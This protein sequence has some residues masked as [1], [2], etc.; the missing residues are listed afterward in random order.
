MFGKCF[1]K[2]SFV[3][4]CFVVKRVLDVTEVEK[5]FMW[6]PHLKVMFVGVCKENCLVNMWWLAAKR[7]FSK[8]LPNNL[9]VAA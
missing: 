5:C 4:V 3:C 8:S 6:D 9:R 1:E 7:Y 2:F